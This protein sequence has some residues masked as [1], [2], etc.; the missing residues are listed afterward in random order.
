MEKDNYI[1]LNPHKIEE[2]SFEIIT[3]ELGHI[4]MPDEYASII[5]R[6]VHTS[7]DF[8]YAKLTEISDNALESAYNALKE[9]CKIYAD[10]NMIVSG[11]SKPALKK[12]NSEIHCL[13]A[14]PA[15]A[16]EAKERGIT[17][18]IVGIDKAADD[19]DTKI[20]VIGNAPTA[21]VRICELINEGKINPALVIG[22][23][24]GFV[25]AAESKEMIREMGVPYIIVNGRKG[26]STI[27][28]A[29]MNAIMYN[30]IR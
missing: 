21:L 18:S 22:V 10:T 15:V 25:G 16:K 14:D 4:N 8:E 7:A 17:R 1:I 19:K 28:V 3:E 29:I 12:L 24:V 5:K 9:G 27:A 30:L 20:Y 11:V 2:R 6:V 23:P 13:V 26:G